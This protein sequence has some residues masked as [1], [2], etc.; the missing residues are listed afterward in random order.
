[1]QIAEDRNGSTK[2]SHLDNT[3]KEPKNAVS[4]AAEAASGQPW[5]LRAISRDLLRTHPKAAEARQIEW[6][7]C[8]ISTAE[9]G[10]ETTV[11]FSNFDDWMRCYALRLDLLRQK[12]RYNE[13]FNW[14][15]ALRFQATIGD[16]EVKAEHVR[17]LERLGV[18]GDEALPPVI[19]GTDCFNPVLENFW[20]PWA[21]Y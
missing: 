14:G 16:P 20:K 17:Y 13:G 1:L 15:A 8:C 12:H 2:Q 18:T 7:P 19:T 3:S 10:T 21:R 6:P 4:K 11:Y 9:L 5:W